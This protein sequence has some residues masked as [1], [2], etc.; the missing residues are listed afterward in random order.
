MIKLVWEVFKIRPQ[1]HRQQNTISTDEIAWNLTAFAQ[2]K[3]KKSTKR[4]GIRLNNCKLSICYKRLI[5]KIY[6]EIDWKKKKLLYKCVKNLNIV[7]SRKKRE[8]TQT[9]CRY[10][11]RCKTSI[12]SGEWKLEPKWQITSPLLQTTIIRK[13]KVTSEEKWILVHCWW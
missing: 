3:K 12:F 11:K 7:L 2:Q 9:L 8:R 13:I 5:N 4:S 10:K 6:E 1:K